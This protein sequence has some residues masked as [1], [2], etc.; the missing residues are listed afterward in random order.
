MD[1]EAK[2][3]DAAAWWRAAWGPALLGWVAGHAAQLTQTALWTPAAYGAVLLAGLALLAW[4]R[5]RR[6]TGPRA[7]LSVALA[8]ALLAW[9]H[10]G[11]RA[12]ERMARL[13]PAALDG[14]VAP[15]RWVVTGLPREEARATTFEARLLG[16][17]A[18]A[19]AGLPPPDR[20]GALRL[21]WRAAQ[22]GQAAPRVRPGE[23]WRGVL[24]LQRPRGLAN[25]YGFDVETWAW[26]EGIAATATVQARGAAPPQRLADEPGQAPVARARAEVRAAL[27]A[28]LQ[29]FDDASRGLVVALVTGDQ[30]AIPPAQW[31]VIRAT[32]VAHLVAISGLH[33]TMFAALALGAVGAAWRRLGARWPGLILRAPTPLV[34][35]LAAVALAAA[36]A[37]FA[38]GGVPAQRTVAM[39]AL[40][41]GLRLLGRSWPWPWVWLAALAAALAV[42]PWAWLQPGFWLSFV[43]VAVL[44]VRGHGAA[45]APDGQGRLRA[46]LREFWGAQWAVTVGLAP[47][48]L[49]W[50]GQVSLV[51]LLANAIAIPWITWG[52]T[53]LA[54]LGV[55]LPPLV[56]AAA[57]LAR[58]LWALLEP[59]ARWPAAVWS[60]PA[61]PWALALAGTAGALVLLQRGP[62][63]LRAWGGLLLW[64]ALA[65]RPAA[66]PPGT[67]E[68]L[69]PDVGQGSAAIV[70]TA[71]HTLVVD[72]GPPLPG[73]SAAERALL[74]WLRAL[75]AVPDAVVLSHD[76]AD[77]AGGWPVLAAAYPRAAWWAPNGQAPAGLPVAQL[78]EAGVGWAWDGVPF[79]FLHP[80]PG[81]GGDRDGN[82]RS[83]VLLVGRGISAA[84]LPGD[85]P[86]AVEAALV[87]AY[88]GLRAGLLV[89]AHHGSRTSTSAA[90][91]DALQPALVAIQAGW[92]NPYGH[93]H[94]EVLRRLR[95]R[96]LA[97]A[98]TPDCGAL[99]WRSDAPGQWQCERARRRFYWQG[100]GVMPETAAVL[101]GTAATMAGDDTA[102]SNR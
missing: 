54:L 48:L 63:P 19:P 13:W 101:T 29:G 18:G 3:L 62:W 87:A 53:P 59:M 4:A 52:V 58:G 32:G 98:A 30:A 47:L 51:G 45:V 69:L 46:W 80:P 43:A 79:I 11:G 66:P 14:A 65:F 23:V 77:H 88:P 68:V 27:Q 74:P 73:G 96:G 93:P 97:V 7:A 102:P 71:R 38:G 31:D 70:R 50:F 15:A 49:F 86:Q 41:L 9:A 100:G 2:Q 78:C 60:R 55:A 75:G 94:A 67:F 99:T 35:S 57:W 82:A 42:D 26:R 83:C 64:P 8:L 44:F 39:L 22:P 40:V 76:D 28:R 81:W 20:V 17:E 36:Y 16:W 12:V 10:A 89:A 5:G 56:D 84:L 1:R 85:I 33:V 61:L 6:E 92:R 72:T 95:E 37:L 24:R 90:W 25:P 91:L 21:T 34:A